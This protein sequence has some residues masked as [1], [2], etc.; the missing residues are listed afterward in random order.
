M[1]AILDA[2]Q[3]FTFYARYSLL[4]VV[5]KSIIN[6]LWHFTVNFTVIFGWFGHWSLAAYVIGKCCH[7]HHCHCCHPAFALQWSWCNCWIA[8]SCFCSHMY[9]Y[10]WSI[11]RRHQQCSGTCM[12]SVA[13]LLCKMYPCT[14]FLVNTFYCSEFLWGV[15]TDTVVWYLHM[16]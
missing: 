1:P 3:T 7:L 2:L 11:Y 13:G 14:V 8:F 10:A 15:Y 12:Y 5:C 9:I 6:S 16:N 4:P